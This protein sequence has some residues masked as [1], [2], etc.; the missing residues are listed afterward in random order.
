MITFHVPW[1]ELSVLW[2]LIGALVV[3]QLHNP[4]LARRASL[5]ACGLALA[6]AIG[7][8]SEMGTIHGVDAHDPW[9]LVAKIRGSSLL[10]IDEL[11]A[12]LLPLSALLYLLTVLATLR[13]KVRRLSFGGLLISEAMLLATLACK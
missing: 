9:D 6:C 2:P 12:P 4:D 1:L 8:W 5:V 10:T 13:T 7:A 11:S 3:R